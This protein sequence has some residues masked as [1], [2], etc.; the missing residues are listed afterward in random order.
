MNHLEQL[1]AYLRAHDID[2]LVVPSTDEYLSEFTREPYKRLEWAT[3]FSGSTGMAIV[4]RDDAAIFVDGRYRLQAERETVGLAITVCDTGD[5]AQ[6]E[7]LSGKREA[8]RTLGIDARVTS[9]NELARLERIGESCGIAVASL[10]ANPIDAIWTDREDA[11]SGSEIFDYALEF[12]GRSAA[13]KI[14]RIAAH[15]G[16]RGVAGHLV[17]DPE[18]VAWLLNVRTDD[19]RRL[20]RQGWQ[21]LPIP[22]TRAFV[23][24]DGRTIWFVDAARLAPALRERVAADGIVLREPEAIEPFL[25]QLPQGRYSANLG[26]TSAG[27]AALTRQAGALTDDPVVAHTRWRK[28]SQEIAAARPGY[29]KDG[30]ATIRFLAWLHGSIGSQNISEMEAAARLHAF[31]GEDPAYRGPSMPF[32]SSA[33]P[34]AAMPHYVPKAETAL[35]LNDHP[36]FLLDSGAQ[37]LG[38][39]TDNTLTTALGR[40]EA[41]H[42]QAH[43]L[44][45][46]GWIA[47][48][49]AIF[50][51]GT[52]SVQLDAIARQPL[53]DAGMD[54]RHGTGHGVGNYMN[55]H[56]GPHIRPQFDHPMI[57]EIDLGMIIANEPGLYR[58]GDFGIRVESHMAVVPGSFEGFL[59]FETLSALPIDPNLIDPTLLSAAE[60]Q[61]LQ[62][63]HR[64]LWG[65]YQDRL[66]EAAAAWL[67]DWVAKFD[68]MRVAEAT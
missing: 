26:R 11:L 54:Y 1:Q 20:D 44:V 58:Q 48:A 52:S 55:I 22:L 25:R 2:G 50:P 18:D 47:L 38:C 9:L 42:V 45:I 66:D 29:D 4:L 27:H 19:C 31:R 60:L 6:I 21:I 68:A 57:A 13:E 30:L 43:T 23:A 36:L 53:W 7:W 62:D 34:S 37:Y 33:G 32:M 15:L 3:R 41:R 49:T 64:G 56:E 12:A 39:S 28:T 59:A 8:V 5:A 46:K 17:S 24:D 14:D 35:R 51:V 10:A 65:R 61:W 63:Y 40:P 67:A 16:D